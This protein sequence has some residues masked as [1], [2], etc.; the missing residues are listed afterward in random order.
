MF[1]KFLVLLFLIQLIQFQSIE[2][3]SLKKLKARCRAGLE[4][5][6]KCIGAGVPLHGFVFKFKKLNFKVTLRQT[7]K[8][9]LNFRQQSY[10]RQPQ[11]QPYVQQIEQTLRRNSNS[12]QIQELRQ[13]I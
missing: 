2:C 1:I 12:Q 9:N 10:E 11:N 4:P 6:Q 8:F 13:Q 7:I 3:F 5:F